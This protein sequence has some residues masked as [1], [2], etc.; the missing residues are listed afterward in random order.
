MMIVSFALASAA[1]GTGQLASVQLVVVLELPMTIIGGS[2]LFGTRLSTRTWVSIAAMTA[3]VIGLL[4]LLAPRP[5][6]AKTIT[7][8][9]WILTSAANIGAVLVLFMAGRAS[10]RPAA[11]A[12]LPGEGGGLLLR[13]A[14]ASTTGQT[15]AV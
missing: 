3:G 8:T 5:G 6:P 1:L 13:P 12:S 9:L 15:R 10:S 4:A 14:A 7:P 11:R 2:L